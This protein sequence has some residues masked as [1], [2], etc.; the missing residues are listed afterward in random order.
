M[1][2]TLTVHAADLQVGD[3]FR[4]TSTPPAGVTPNATRI[5]EINNVTT[6]DQFGRLE[7]TTNVVWQRSSGER[8]A[9]TYLARERV[10]IIRGDD[11]PGDDVLPA[12]RPRLITG[13]TRPN[14]YAGP[15]RVCRRTVAPGA[16]VIIRRSTGQ[17]RWEVQH[18]NLAECRRACVEVPMI[19]APHIAQA[20]PA[21]RPTADET[22]RRGDSFVTA[23]DAPGHGTITVDGVHLRVCRVSVRQ[24]GRGWYL[25][26]W[27]GTG[28]RFFRAGH[29]GLRGLTPIS[30]EQAAEFGRA[31][32]RCVFCGRGLDTPESITVGYGPDCA[33]QRGL[34]WGNITEI[35]RAVQRQRR[36]TTAHIDGAVT[37][38]SLR[39][40]LHSTI[41]TV[42]N[43]CGE[44]CA[45]EA[46]ASD[47]A[48]HDCA[49]APAA[50]VAG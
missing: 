17:S 46:E 12:D 23:V 25:N 48:A 27:D 22:P 32:H 3:R 45:T 30:P 8:V 47:P 39:R 18:R 42:C 9:R 2:E 35:D 14:Q 20:E 26:T 1:P 13:I 38:E 44:E 33:A 40:A 29:R 7:F 28:W 4:S 6:R 41:P 24:R 36:A 19:D 15:C 21:E 49:D 10:T 16:G 34:P 43:L 31:Y 50:S 11:E 5:V 37:A